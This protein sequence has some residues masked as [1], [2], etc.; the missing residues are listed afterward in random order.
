[1]FEVTAQM[2]S[3]FREAFPFSGRTR[4]VGL[5]RLAGGFVAGAALATGA[6]AVA[7]DT[8]NGRRLY[9]V[10]CR[11]CH[12][13]RARGALAGVPDLARGSALIRRD[14]DL[15]SSILAGAGTMPGFLGII[16]EREAYDL[17]AYLRLLL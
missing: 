11:D 1:M 8:D 13:P 10:H 7:A 16:R 12:G 5:R 2:H 4:P 6:P 17:V 15:V 3:R 9:E 14:A